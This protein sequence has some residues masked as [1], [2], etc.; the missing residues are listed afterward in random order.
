MTRRL[1]MLKPRVQ[2]LP[3]R[4]PMAQQATGFTST[5]RMRGRRW[6]ERR[7]R[8]L[9]AHPMCTTCEAQGR[10]SVATEVDHVIPLWKG[11]ADD[12][13]NYQSQCKP[14]HAIKSAREASER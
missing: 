2:T 10:L 8:W 6:V 9:R 5:P 12:E 11:G 7:A 1:A 13:D 14:C 4:V 3:G